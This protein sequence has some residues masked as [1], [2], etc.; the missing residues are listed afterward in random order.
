MSSGLK[1]TQSDLK[2]SQE[3]SYHRLLELEVLYR[4]APVGLGFLDHELRYVRLNEALAEINDLSVEA[5][6][7]RYA[8]EIDPGLAKIVVPMMAQVLASKQPL[9]NVEIT[10]TQLADVKRER[11]WMVNFHPVTNSQ[12]F[13]VSVVFQDITVLK[14]TEDI[15]TR[16]GLIVRDM[17]DTT[18]FGI[19][20]CGT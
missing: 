16:F 12:T 15:C 20:H 6:I 5:H 19:V 11:T 7:G 8:S 10:S 13:G 1:Q 14:E 2:S 3:E 18:D 9:L 4:T 17:E